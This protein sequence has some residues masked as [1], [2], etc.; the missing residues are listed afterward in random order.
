MKIWGRW[1][2]CKPENGSD[3]LPVR[4]RLS[5]APAPGRP[6]SSFFPNPAN[7]RVLRLLLL[8]ALLAATATAAPAQE[9][10]PGPG[11]PAGPECTLPVL[12]PPTHW[13]AGAARRLAA[14]GPYETGT[15]ATGSLPARTVAHELVAARSA[16][17]PA[18]RAAAELYLSLLARE[19]PQLSGTGNGACEPGVDAR[20]AT[21]Y[22]GSRGLRGPG[23]GYDRDH[24]WTGAQPLDALSSP[25][26][27][28][29]LV[30]G[31]GAIG[32]RLDAMAHER[33]LEIRDLH[34]AAELGDVVVWAGRRQFR[35]GPGGVGGVVF[36]GEALV[37]G[38]GAVVTDPLR[39]PWVLGLLG[40]IGMESFFSRARGGERIIDPWL[41][42]AR[43]TATPHPRFR[44][45][46]S[47]G[48]MFGGEGNTP[49]TVRHALQMLMGMHSG[50][51]GEF[52]NHFGAVDL[53][54]RP[55]GLPLDLYLEWG[56]NDSAGAWR[57]IPA[58]LLGIRWVTLP[59]APGVGVE[60]ELV[61]FPAECCGNPMWYRN[62]AMRMG[63]T[64]DGSPLGHPLGGHG[65]EWSLRMDGVVAGGAVAADG[66]IFRRDRG[67]DNLFAPEWSGP[68]VGGEVS[69]R[70]QPGPGP[71]GVVRGALESGRD[72]RAAK[73]FAGLTWS[74]GG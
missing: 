2:W 18:A 16:E 59:F 71:G 3:F 1:C 36:G 13:A 55:P 74:F 24:D 73:L 15:T 14:A 6:V 10:G 63:W 22:V 43:I 45:G 48:T 32:G 50:E 29:E 35:H 20:V 51:A 47:R 19:Y 31:R 70:L 68:S 72:W 12:L 8:T 28:L 27:A 38:V 60:A 66:R 67:I 17:S 37:T 9:D 61:H 21:G 39:L 64:H 56:M 5:L 4:A 69:L 23:F 42:G 58:R 30:G 46:A 57:D 40:P 25:A 33:G 34:V 41:W 49:V 44:I 54:Y 7:G 65:T 26:A 62:W 52:D 53:R 11:G